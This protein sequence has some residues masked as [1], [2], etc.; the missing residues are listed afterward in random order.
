MGPRVINVNAVPRRTRWFAYVRA[1]G[2]IPFGLIGETSSTE[3]RG[4]EMLNVSLR[5][6]DFGRYED[7]RLLRYSESRV[8]GSRRR[9][10]WLFSDLSDNVAK[11]SGLQRC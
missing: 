1:V 8:F 11:A 10:G 3:T 4:D 2:Y 6:T 7:Y 5:Q 9:N